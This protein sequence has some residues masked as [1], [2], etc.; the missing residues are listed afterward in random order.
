[1]PWAAQVTVGCV[2]VL[3]LPFVDAVE[4]VAAS[5]GCVLVYY[6]LTNAAAFPLGGRLLRPLSV[7]G[8]VGCLA[9]VA[10]L[11]L[12]GVLWTVA[13]VVAGLLLGRLT[14]RGRPGS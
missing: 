2:V 3:A 6:A 4:A 1:V 12:V 11:P 5:S 14:G 13:V 9:L 8:L 10:S 7:L